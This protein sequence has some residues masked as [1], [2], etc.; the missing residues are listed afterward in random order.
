MDFILANCMFS[1]EKDLFTALLCQSK[2]VQA[3][4]GAAGLGVLAQ[5]VF[6]K[7]KTFKTRLEGAVANVWNRSICKAALQ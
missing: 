2:A 4:Q 6:N 5:S 7:S 1:G 3:V